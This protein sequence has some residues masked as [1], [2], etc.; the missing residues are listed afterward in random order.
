MQ[1]YLK[2]GKEAYMFKNFRIMATIFVIV[3]C[4]ASMFN[5]S[6]AASDFPKKGKIVTIIVP[7]SAG[8]STD[9]EA[10]LI[11]PLLEKKIGAT[12]QIV[13]KPGAATQVGM[14]ELTLSKNDGYT[15]LFGSFPGTLIPAI[16]STRQATYTLKDFMGISSFSK[17]PFVFAVSNDSPFKSIKDVVE[18]AK[19]N[20]EKFKVAVT[21]ILL[22]PHLALLELEKQTK[23]KFSPVHFDGAA[24]ART[25]FMGGH[26]DGLIATVSEANVAVKG[27]FARIIGVMDTDENP[28][29]S[30]VKTMS[31]Q[32][33]KV[34]MTTSQIFVA[35]A[36]VPSE[37]VKKIE[38]SLMDASKNE[39]YLEKMK[40]FGATVK[41]RGAHE[42][43]EYL[44]QLANQ[45]KPLIEDARKEQK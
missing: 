12:V 31:D 29:A 6:F 5:L 32:G 2:Q 3:I 36:G 25:A 18:Y 43:Q 44:L 41:F 20:P 4:I 13:N 17:E 10:R 30:N 9:T 15:L 34:V 27:N 14:T 7:Y 1:L 19:A 23:I 35:P 40:Q 21:G 26:T 28:E 45:I 37:I 33:Y 38:D 22:P 39:Q 24:P 16:D 8:G 42:S 11:A